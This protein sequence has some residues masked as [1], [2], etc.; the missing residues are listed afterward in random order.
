MRSMTTEDSLIHLEAE[1]VR[2]RAKSASLEAELAKERAKSAR[3]EA[4]LAAVQAEYA[5]LHL[6][7]GQL[8]E[9]F[10]LVPPAR[11]PTRAA[12]PHR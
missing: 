1:L 12:K 6:A 11:E 9:Q 2:E 10:K 4:D 7:H 5:S 8:L 3:L